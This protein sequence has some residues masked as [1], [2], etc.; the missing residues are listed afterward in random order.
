MKTG[1]SSGQ[2]SEAFTEGHR[3]LL[4]VVSYGILRT[5]LIDKWASPGAKGLRSLGIEGTHHPLI[6]KRLRTSTS[7]RFELK[8]GAMEDQVSEAALRSQM[9]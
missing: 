7:G 2:A 1:V 6:A 9:D 5:G 8:P 4:F 3:K